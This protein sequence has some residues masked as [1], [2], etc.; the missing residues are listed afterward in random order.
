MNSKKVKT[1][2]KKKAISQL[3]R[4]SL[5]S[6]LRRECRNVSKMELKLEEAERKMELQLEEAA[7]ADRKMKLQLEEAAEAQRM[8]EMEL[9]NEKEANQD[10]E[11]ELNSLKLKITAF[12]LFH[13]MEN[14]NN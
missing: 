3:S 14:H 6:H 9:N 8:M 7:E 2:R 10:L 4:S 13:N 11:R 5:E 12:F 1:G